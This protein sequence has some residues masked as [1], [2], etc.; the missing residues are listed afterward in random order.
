[1]GTC[2]DKMRKIYSERREGNHGDIRLVLFLIVGNERFLLSIF[3]NQEEVQVILNGN[4]Y[5]RT[6]IK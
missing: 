3:L 2:K 6:L 1:M 5:I 4:K